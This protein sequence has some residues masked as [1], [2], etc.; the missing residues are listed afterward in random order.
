[1]W[2]DTLGK[3]NNVARKLWLL[4]AGHEDPFDSRRAVW[5]DTLHRWFDHYL[6]GVN[7]GIEKETA[8]TIEDE[9]DVWKD[10]ASWPIDGTQ[11]VDVFLRATDDAA[12]AGTL[13]GIDAAA[14]PTRSA[15]P[16]QSNTERDDAMNTPTGSQTNRRVFLSRTLTKDVRLSGTADGRPRR[17]R[18]AP[19]R[20]TSRVLIAD[21]GAGTQVSRSGNSEGVDQ[22]HDAHLLGRQRRD[23]RPTACAVGRRAPHR[24]RA[25]S[26]TPATSRSTKPLTDRH[27]VARHARHPRLLE[28]RLAVVP[29][30]DAGHDRPAST[31]SSSR[32]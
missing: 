9:A 1:M 4:R 28:P 24:E 22:R 15:T 10:Y 30:R 7:N 29:G 27:P 5:V 11:N 26:T 17:R 14:R 21:Y 23:G 16:S 6:Y 8:V 12:A 13:G 32:R 18:S 20:A 2:W 31:A 25:R 3:A 19:R